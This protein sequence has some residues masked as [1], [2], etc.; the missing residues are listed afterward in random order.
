MPTTKPRLRLRSPGDVVSAVPYLLGFHPA[1]SIVLLGLGGVR[2]ELR[3]SVRLDLPHERDHAH[4]VDLVNHYIYANRV[5]TVLLIVYAGGAV[6]GAL[7]ERTLV[8]AVVARLEGRAVVVR[9]ALCVSAGRW[10]S[11]RCDNDECCPREGTVVDACDVIAATA[12]SHGLVALPTR[13][14]LEETLRPDPD[15]AR[16]AVRAAIDDVDSVDAGVFDAVL[17]RW[18]TAISETEAAVMLVALRDHRVR[19]SLLGQW[20]DERLHALLARLVRMAPDGYVAA[21]AGS[22]ATVTYLRGGGALVGMALE[23]CFADDPGYS[24]ARLI[25]TAVAA[26][27]DPAI[28]RPV[29]ARAAPR[30]ACR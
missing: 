4:F 1:D 13:E 24:L 25:A 3:I 2:K 10:W 8:D 18:P 23:R 20:A 14:S 21:P 19:D 30:R 15:E 16:A 17:A 12:V 7:P 11:Y 29:V 6:A 26:G 27:T 22:F 5:D 9:E 28:V